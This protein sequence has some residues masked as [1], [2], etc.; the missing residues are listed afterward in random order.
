[1]NNNN[2]KQVECF[3]GITTAALVFMMQQASFKVWQLLES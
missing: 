1:M 2:G 3:A